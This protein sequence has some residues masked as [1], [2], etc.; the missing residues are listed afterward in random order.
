MIELK[1]K[2]A[3]LMRGIGEQTMPNIDRTKEALRCC[4]DPNNANCTNPH[5]QQVASDA[6]TIIEEQQK[7]IKRLEFEL[8]WIPRWIPV[9]EQLPNEYTNVLVAK[10]NDERPTICQMWIVGGEKMWVDSDI[11]H[12]M[13]LPKKTE[14]R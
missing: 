3:Q 9:S 11:T 2:N 13:P 10:K 4:S 6:L 12:W 8:E 14:R 5:R 1:L 7:K